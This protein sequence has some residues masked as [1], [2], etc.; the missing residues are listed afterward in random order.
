ME[1]AHK[2]RK[3]NRFCNAC[4]FPEGHFQSLLVLLDLRVL[5]AVG[6]RIFGL[7]FWI[8][9]SRGLDFRDLGFRDF[10]FRDLG[11]FVRV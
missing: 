10:V 2:S 6:F 9:R 5:G 11:V 3:K 4:S 8:P 7:G 1:G